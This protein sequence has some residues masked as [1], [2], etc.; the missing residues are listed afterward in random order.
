MRIWV[1]ML[2]LAASA[3]AQTNRGSISGTVFDAS[4]SVIAGA[5]VTVTS[6]GTN[7]VHKVSTSDAGSFSVPN[8]DPVT[9]RVEVEAAGFKK[10]IVDNVK[11]DTASNATVNVTMETGSVDTSVTVLAEAAMVN[12]ESGTTSST[13]SERE[14]RDVPLVNRSVLDLALT[15]PNVSGDA[16]SENPGLTAGTSCPGCT[17]SV[18]GG[19]PLS[20]QMMADGT[21]NTG[22]SL[23]R[24]MVSF[25]PETVQE[26]TVQ[27]TVYSAEYGT[28]GGGIINAT[29]K[30]GTNRLNGTALWYN[31]NPAFAAAPWTTAANNRPQPTLKYNQFSLSAGGPV[32]IP[33]VYNGKNKTFWFAAYEPFYR[34]DH[35]DQYGLLPTDAMRQGDFS[36]VVNTASGWIPRSVAAQFATIAPAAVAPVDSTIYQ[37]YTLVNGNQFTPITLAT[38]ATATPFPGNVIPKSMQD[39]SALKAVALIAP[40][41]A[42]Y[43]NS[44]GLISN[45]FLPRR[46]RQEEKRYT[47]RIDH[48]ISDKNRV[49]LRFTATPIVKTQDTPLSPTSNGAEYSWAKQA[50]LSDTHTFSASLYNDLRL[51]YTRGRFSSTVAP[52]YDAKTGANINTDLG[53]PNITHGGVPGLNTLFPGSSFGGGGSTATGIGG[54]GSTQN[55]DVEER[56]AITDIVYK[57][58]GAMSFKFGVDVSHALQDV[59]PLFAALGGQYAFAGTQTNSTNTTAGT[60]GAPWASFLLG[61]PNG[62]VTLRNVEIP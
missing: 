16:G 18:G 61:V 25:S 1:A 41:G 39:A 33:K 38:G 22:I 52:E 51:N 4:S 15:L 13:I 24:S 55:E 21:N 5:H 27:T 35:L 59:T 45:A 62:N 12:T 19:R 2:L 10:K 20:T 3:L 47:T 32:W 7:E 46:L 56:Y 36:D 9:Y 48:T 44:N 23:G 17:L 57:V 49:F 26:F 11:V 31:R 54:G 50:M 43:V 14:L 53:L 58:R 37:N 28:T 30:S 34:R 6:V 60:G 42:Y 40:A 8:L 29:T